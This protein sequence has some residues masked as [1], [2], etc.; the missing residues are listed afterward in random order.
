MSSPTAATLGEAQFDGIVSGFYDAASSGRN[1][2]DALDPLPEVFGARAVVLHTTDIVDGRMLALELGGADLERTALEYVTGW[3]RQDPRKHRI[4]KLGPA[5]IGQWL[6]C[7]DA[8][9]DNFHQRNPFFRQFMTGHNAR[10]NSTL[11]I[12]IDGRTVTGFALELH[13]GRPPLDADERELARRLGHHMQQA[14]LSFE[15]MRRLATQVMVGHELLRTFAFPM[16]LLDADRRVQYANEAAAALESTAL[17]FNRRDGRLRLASDQ[18]DRMLTVQLHELARAGHGTRGHVRLGQRGALPE[19]TGWLHLSLLEPTAVMGLAFGVQRSV[20]ATLFRPDH[21]SRLDPYA[22]GQ[23]FAMTPT[24]ARVAALLG[25]GLDPQAIATRLNVKLSTV[26]THIRK[27]L[28]AMGQKRMVDAV[29]LL[30]E[31][32]MLWSAVGDAAG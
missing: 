17:D 19:S 2:H 7:T 16:W 11:V 31:G 13:A 28:T 18:A 12:P 24:E 29:R 15:R 9:D 10:Y 14:L 8:F 27:V 21:L 30:S 23:M 32:Q 1:W 5:V 20:L 22:L 26:R 25:E 6:H 3:E 4:L